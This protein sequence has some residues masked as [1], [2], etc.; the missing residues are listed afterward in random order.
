MEGRR[1]EYEAGRRAPRARAGPGR[2]GDDAATRETWLPATAESA[3]MARSLV[4]EVAPEVGLDKERAWD[5]SLAT[6]EAVAN[7]I[8]HGEAWANGCILLT[9]EPCP[10][11]LRVE[12]CDCG[13]FDSSL[14]PAPMEATSG[15]GI[16][17]I[18]T[19]V[20]RLEVERRAGLTRVS[21]EKHRLS[22]LNGAPTQATDW[23]EEDVSR[24]A[25]VAG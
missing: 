25:R 5:L 19:M 18:A 6:T 2:M 9:I 24:N 10:R 14:E 7:A 23:C 20:D 4:R 17:I 16:Q 13:T 3:G 22:A 1:N 15:R 12:V 8:T 21:F 11:G